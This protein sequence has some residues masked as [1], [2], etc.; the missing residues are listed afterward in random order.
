[1]LRVEAVSKKFE[2]KNHFAVDGVSFTLGEAEIMS[3]IGESGCGKT[4]LLRCLAGLYDLDKG[5]ILINDE[6]LKGPKFRLVPGHPNIE[7]VFQDYELMPYHTV[8]ENVRYKLIQFPNDYQEKR[9]LEV[10]KICKIIELKDEVP[11][12]LSGGQ[13]QRIALARAIAN[14]PDLILLDEPFSNLDNMLRK[15]FRDLIK[16]INQSIKTSF[17]FV[18]HD[19]PD[20][21]AISDKLAVML[22]GKFI[23]FGTPKD[24]YNHPNSEYSARFFGNPNILTDQD[25][26]LLTGSKSNTEKNTIRPEK[27]KLQDGNQEGHIT[28]LSFLGSYYEYE[29]TSKEGIV[30]QIESS[31]DYSLGDKVQFHIDEKDILPLND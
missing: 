4:T 11:G 31:L 24:V 9:T 29:V 7:M 25:V 15:G 26:K 21:L 19:T 3:I 16:E 5:K 28:H 2:G 30:L 22:N 27:I 14:E 10:L 13:Q 20:A 23:Q 8:Y 6:V 12:N 18:S 17:I 1:M